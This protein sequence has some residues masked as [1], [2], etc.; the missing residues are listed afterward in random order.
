M[1]HIIVQVA[2]ILAL[3]ATSTRAGDFRAGAAI[4][5]ITPK[6]FPVVVNGGMLSRTTNTVHSPIHARAIAL[7]DGET[8][9]AIVV[10]DSCMMPRDLLDAAKKLAAANTGIPASRMLISATHAHSAPSCFAALGTDADPNYPG[11]VAPLLAQVI[12]S[13]A[14]RLE[15]AEI[16]FAIGNAAEFTALRRWIR[17][18]DKILRDPFGNPT[19]RAN[20]HPGYRSP[21]AVGPSGPEDPDLSVISIRSRNGRPLALLANFS[22]HYYTEA[23]IGADYFGLFSNRIQKRIATD[24]P[25]FVAMMSHGCSGDIWLRDYLKP[26]PKKPLH[27]LSSYSD[28]LVDI[29]LNAYRS[30][31]YQTP[32]SLAMAEAELPLRYRVPDAQQLEWARGVVSRMK[33]KLPENR[34]EVYAREA[35]FL[36]EKQ[37]TRL[38]LQVLRIGDIGITAIPNEVYALTGLKLKAR[39]PFDRTMTIELANGAEGYI[40]PPEQH[41]FGGYNTWAARSAG[42]E[43]TAEPKI[44]ETVLA[45][46]EK[47]A[48]RPRR[49]PRPSRG[50]AAEAVLAAK[51][52]SYWRLH[53]MEHGHAHDELNRHDASYDGGV[54]YYLKG[55]R[56]AKF[57]AGDTNRCA[58]LVDGRVRVR[59]PEIQSNYSV[60]IWIW[61]GVPND[62]R[63]LTGTIF[64][65]GRDVSQRG[66]HLS[67]AGT[68]QAKPGVLLYSSEGSTPVSQGA[69]VLKRWTWHHV[70]LTRDEG[71]V[72]VYLDGRTEFEIENTTAA[73][74]D[75]LFFGG[76]SDGSSFLEGRIDEV[77]VFDRTL[78]ATEVQD[79]FSAAK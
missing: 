45:L 66:E 79:L 3:S 34:T 60:S 39:S 35:I 36:N 76:H 55:P 11:F 26:A 46:L 48:S 14:K 37:D 23:A 69:S 6:A 59:I 32:D 75:Q 72:R 52:V 49:D 78:S 40:P 21:D 4:V 41:A 28:S 27:D 43:V 68:A 9:I 31:E 53:E 70:V 15:P 62:A 8:K 67:I 50:P 19:V 44:V 77:S 2:S 64:S 24:D 33:R 13:A 10:V 20:M 74:V 71:R 65:R 5:D 38:I 17:R 56:S 61:N 25:N 12:G 47:V 18:S 58:H 51:P 1:R 16:G 22:M 30:I 42:L 73:S 29:A 7:D 63:A 57:H 54:A